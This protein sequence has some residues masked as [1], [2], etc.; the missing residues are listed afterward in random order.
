MRLI[1]LV[2]LVWV[3]RESTPKLQ[4]GWC[5]TAPPAHL[6]SLELTQGRAWKEWSL[7]RRLTE[8]GEI[9]G[10]DKYFESSNLISPNPRTTEPTPFDS[11]QSPTPL[12]IQF[13]KGSTSIPGTRVKRRS[14]RNRKVVRRPRR[15]KSACPSARVRGAA[16]T[17]VRLE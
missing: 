16:L 1:S 5:K 6:G 7:E 17:L 8:R 14:K 11:R 10:T 4:G 9:C 12:Q 15:A 3:H 13:G 2:P